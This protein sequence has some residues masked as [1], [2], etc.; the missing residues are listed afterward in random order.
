L[1]LFSTQPT[2]ISSIH[3]EQQTFFPFGSVKDS[4]SPF[5]D[6]IITPSNSLYT[7]AKL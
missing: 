3:V 5:I 4:S 1:D 2:N 7:I 6:F